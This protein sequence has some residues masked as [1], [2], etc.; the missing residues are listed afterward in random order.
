MREEVDHFYEWMETENIPTRFTHRLEGELQFNYNLW[1]SEQCGLGQ[2]GWPRWRQELYLT[3]GR[4]RRSV[5]LAFRDAPLEEYV[6]DALLEAKADAE[7]Q[8]SEL[9]SHCDGV[10]GLREG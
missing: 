9:R 5:G 7:R 2:S 10:E 1:L 3:T 8:W 6:G 4:L